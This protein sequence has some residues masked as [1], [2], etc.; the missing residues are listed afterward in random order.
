MN[1]FINILITLLYWSILFFILKKLNIF[2]I[3]KYVLLFCG[4]VGYIILYYN[5][6]D[7]SFNLYNYL[8]IIFTF[9]YIFIY[10]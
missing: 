4:F 10:K 7:G 8:I 2:N 6:F 3:I 1:I 9:V 5:L